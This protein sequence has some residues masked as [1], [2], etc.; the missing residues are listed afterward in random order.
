MYQ[1]PT[2]RRSAYAYVYHEGHRVIKG[3]IVKIEGDSEY[4]VV[5]FGNGVNKRDPCIEILSIDTKQSLRKR[6]SE[7]TPV[8]IDPCE[9]CDC[10]HHLSYSTYQRTGDFGANIQGDQNNL[11]RGDE[12]DIS[13]NELVDKLESLTVTNRNKVNKFIDKFLNN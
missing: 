6:V 10:Q 11:E 9:E 1:T 4:Y 3:D 7:V 5:V 12:P 8:C 13:L 2:G